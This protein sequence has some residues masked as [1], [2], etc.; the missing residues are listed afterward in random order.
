M[1]TWEELKAEW[2]AREG[3]LPIINTCRVKIALGRRGMD[4]RRLA[5][6]LRVP[7]EEV[8]PLVTQPEDECSPARTSPETIERI[9]EL[10]DFPPTFFVHGN[11]QEDWSAYNGISVELSRRLGTGYFWHECDICP[12]ESPRAKTEQE[13]LTLARSTGWLI[14]TDTDYAECPACLRASAKAT[15]ASAAYWQTIEQG[16]TS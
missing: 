15:E 1:S 13:A 10:T 2:A 6:A 5:Q 8:R 7:L 3:Y 11:E 4:A 14:L 9:S 12:E 16:L